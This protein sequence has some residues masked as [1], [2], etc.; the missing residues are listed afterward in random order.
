[1]AIIGLGTVQ[2]GV[3]YGNRADFDLMP[4]EEA[5]LIVKEAVQRGIRFF[6]TAIAYGLSEQRLGQLNLAN[7][8]PNVLIST[9][10]P[11]AAPEIY[12]NE[13]IYFE[14]VSNHCLNSLQRLNMPRHKL[15]QFHQCDL[16]FLESPSVN[17]VF[18][19]LIE[20]RITEEIGVSVY[21]IEQAMAALDGNIVKWLQVPANLIDWRFLQPD[22]LA[23]VSSHNAKLIVRSAVLQGVLVSNAALPNVRKS[24]ELLH[25]RSL[26]ED[27]ISDA[28]LTISLEEASLRV[29]FGNFGDA[30]KIV[31]LGVDSVKSLDSNLKMLERGITPLP[32]NLLA[33]LALARQYAMDL[34]LYNPGTWN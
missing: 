29:L 22:F 2:L 34:E 6:D 24:K 10:I 8:D 9:K 28:G 19:K 12:R 25:L 27:A 31:L 26:C 5:G 15:L 11:I 20:L 23:F 32:Q 30:L 16:A 14:W 21:S 18:N 33:K 13:K 7:M 3:P 4:L 1:M 17:A